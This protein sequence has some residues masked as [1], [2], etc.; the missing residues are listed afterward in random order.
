M[1]AATWPI[2]QASKLANQQAS[3]FPKNH[4]RAAQ[5]TAAVLI[6]RNNINN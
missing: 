4:Q 6:R 2:N 5:I 3:Q 1:G